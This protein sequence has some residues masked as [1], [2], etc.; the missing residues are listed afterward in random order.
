V[1]A[2]R[3]HGGATARTARDLAAR[4]TPNRAADRAPQRAAGSFSQV[5]S[6]STP[7]SS[8]ASGPRQAAAPPVSAAVSLFEEL[9]DELFGLPHRAPGLAHRLG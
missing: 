2:S 1:R 3:W 8:T 4:L 5:A 6:A 7:E 9:L